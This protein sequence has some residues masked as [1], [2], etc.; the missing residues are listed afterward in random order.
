V[1]FPSWRRKRQDQLEEELQSHL[2]MATQDRADRGE[3]SAQAASSARREF[4]NVGLVQAVARDQW[5][6]TWLEELLQDL[7]YAART[8]RKNPGFTAIAVLTLALGIGA[9]T[10]IFSV[11]YAAL[12]KSLPYPQPDRLVMVWE[13]V[14]SP[15]FQNDRNETTP[16]NFSD[17]RRQ[18]TLFGEMAAFR[19]RSFNLTGAGEPVRVEGEAV[20][21]GFFSALRTNAAMGRLFNA[22]DDQAGGAHVVVMSD[23]L[24]K[25][26]FASDVQMVG[27]TIVLDGQGYTVIGVMPPR[28][29]FPDPDDQLWVP[30]GLSAADL[31]DRRSHFLYVFGRL[32]PSATLAQAQAEMNLT[33]RH[34]IDLYPETNSGQS[35]NV[36]PLLDEVTG[37]VRPALLALLAAVSLLLLIVCA[38]VANLLLARASARHREIAVR[39]A[40]GASPSRILRQLLTE[41]AL[42]A[43]LGSA[44]GLLLAG[45]GIGG[46]RLLSPPHIPRTDDIFLGGPVLFFSMGVSILVGLVFGL[47]PALQAARASVH[48]SLTE[49]SRGSASGSG[50]QARNF[51]VIA[52]TALGV[53]VVIGAGLLLRS[54]LMIGQV[55]LGFNPRGVLTFRV[56]PRGEKYLQLPQRTAFYQ[57]ALQRIEALPGIKSAAAESFMPLTFFRGN[58]AFSIQGLPAAPGQLSMAEY[59]VVTPNYF[60]TME[61]SLLEGRAFSWSDSPQ[62]QPVAIVN[63]AM[64]REYWPGEDPLGKRLRQGGPND[65]LPWTTIVGVVRNIRYFDVLTPPRPTVYFP[66]SQ[67]PDAVG[68][69]RDWVVRTAGDPLAV[70]SGV[71][72]AI[73]QVDKNLPVSRLRSM[74]QV[75]AISVAPQRFNL[76][77]FGLFAALA[78]LLASVGIYGVMT[79]SVAQRTRE[80]GIRTA[81]GARP[82]DILHQVLGQGMTLAFT[83]AAIGIVVAL[84]VTR[85]LRSMLYGVAPTDLLTFAGVVVLLLVVSLAAC[86][87]PARRAMRVDPM[88][89]LRYE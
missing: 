47:A 52:E 20:T 43:L 40:L 8:L 83:G 19:N 77:L 5:G 70:A 22:E 74:E 6:W 31:N 1:K 49:G 21:A 41:S 33:A 65:A 7:R 18:N 53:I 64:A 80:L 75:R 45:W 82:A 39:L 79:Y 13:S 73:W 25:T 35:V 85:Y 24:W 48:D 59:D 58:K 11:V 10:A 23:G 57:E 71:R 86:Y 29:H 27:K 16:G 78:L 63:E 81:L 62:A 30:L 17:W 61:I 42:L 32:K 89:A 66:T 51:L 26:R 15:N 60:Q 55:P 12:I 72:E 37:A 88:V 38:N 54:L 36:V 67:F 34:L 4:G 2:Q 84:G 44:L 28:F 76:L 69:L 56:I 87:I 9:S 46:I 68:I 50:L 3:S 14:R